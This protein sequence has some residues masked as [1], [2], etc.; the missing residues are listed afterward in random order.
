MATLLKYKNGLLV[1]VNRDYPSAE[2]LMNSSKQHLHIKRV[3][4]E[5]RK[6]TS[7]KMTFGY[8]VVLAVTIITLLNLAV[9]QVV[10]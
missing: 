9:V 8:L 1:P 7:P 10:S 3:L 5:K 2:M 6:M 4:T